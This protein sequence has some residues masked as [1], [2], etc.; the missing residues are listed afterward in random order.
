MFWRSAIGSIL[1]A[2]L[3]PSPAQAACPKLTRN[4]G[5]CMRPV[6]VFDGDTSFWE[7]DPDLAL[8]GASCSDSNACT[9]G[10]HCSGGSC[11]ASST[12]TCTASD[13]C[14]DV[15]TCNPSTGGCSNPNKPNNTAC[16]DHT[17]CTQGESCQYGVC[18]SPTFTVSCNSPSQCQTGTGACNAT[19]GNCSY[20][21]KV[22]GSSCDDG[23]IC[24][25]GETC[26]SGVCGSPTANSC[27]LP[28]VVYSYDQIGNLTSQVPAACQATTCAAQGKTCDTMSDGCGATLNCGSCVVGQVCLSSGVC[29][30]PTTCAAQGMN[31]DSISDGCGG[32]L[33]CGTCP[34]G[35]VCG[36]NNVC[37]C[38][39]GALC[40]PAGYTLCGSSCD[41]LNTDANN[42]GACGNVC[43]G[44]LNGGPSCNNGSCHIFCNFGYQ[45]CGDGKCVSASCP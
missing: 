32:T 25:S 11:V 14:H 19:T 10:D 37:I 45:N 29:C 15:G 26:Q 20:A 43:P 39:P 22:N 33:S 12:V 21:N 1:L 18:G 23:L 42:C 28:A 30:Q 35:Y 16:D 34:A 24:T 9:S 31:C 5:Q 41:N 4:C 27:G 13:Q 44:T 8:D 3:S 38:A 17:A 6:C 36:G 40:C 7:C 2:V